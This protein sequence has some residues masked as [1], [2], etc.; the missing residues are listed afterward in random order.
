MKPVC[1]RV[2]RAL[3]ALA[4]ALSFG[5]PAYAATPGPPP[6]PFQPGGAHCVF[7]TGYRF[8]NGFLTLDYTQD[9][10][11]GGKVPGIGWENGGHMSMR[12]GIVNN[13]LWI[14]SFFGRPALITQVI[15]EAPK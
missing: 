13:Q 7:A 8:V 14:R 1:S 9:L 2:S 11:Q 10:N 5:V 3:V 12:V 6:T 15:T 4:I